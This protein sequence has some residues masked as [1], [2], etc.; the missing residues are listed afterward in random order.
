[1]R[2]WLACK[3]NGNAC[4]KWTQDLYSINFAK[5]KRLYLW[6]KMKDCFVMWNCPSTWCTKT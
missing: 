3:V 6:N 4:E 1:M 5:K 2:D